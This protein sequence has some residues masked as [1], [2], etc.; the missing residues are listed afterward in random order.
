MTFALQIVLGLL[1]GFAID[2]ALR[3]FVSPLMQAWFWLCWSGVFAVAGTLI[4]LWWGVALNLACGVF[5]VRRIDRLRAER[6]ERMKM[7]TRAHR[8]L[9]EV[10]RDHGIAHGIWN[11]S[12]HHEQA[13]SELAQRLRWKLPQLSEEERQAVVALTRETRKEIADDDSEM[14]RPG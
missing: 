11:D 13:R 5:C 8:I 2:T 1:I 3:R 7:A 4:E 12:P 9:L 10:E 6:N 14:G